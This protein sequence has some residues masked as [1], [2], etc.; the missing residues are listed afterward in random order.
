MIADSR[1]NFWLLF[2]IGN[3]IVLQ[4]L[5]GEDDVVGQFSLIYW[6]LVLPALLIPL[7]FL[8]GIITTLGGRAHFLLYFFI[9]AGAFHLIRGDFRTV[10]QL[11]LLILVLAWCACESTHLSTDDVIKIFFASLILGILVFRFTDWNFWGLLPG[12]T[13][14]EYGGWRVSYF[15]NVANTGTMSLF[16]FLLLTRKIS[17]AKNHKFALLVCLYFLVFSFVRAAFIAAG[18]YL[19][20]RFVFNGSRG[21]GPR[22]LFWASLGTGVGSIL[23][24]AYIVPILEVLQQV[25]ALSRLLLRGQAELDPAAI[26]QQLYRPWLWSQH[27]L[28]FLSSPGQMGL[29]TFN[30]SEHVSF[31]LVPG[32]GGDG[33]ESLPTRLLA[34]YGL[35]SLFFAGYVVHELAR[36]ARA[37]DAWGCA[38]FPGIL[39]MLMNWGS[40]FHPT[41]AFFVLFFL[42]LTR[43]ASAL[44]DETEKKR[45]SIDLSQPVS[46]FDRRGS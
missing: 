28:M 46:S 21:K 24:A 27:F 30:F 11:L 20:L 26:Y 9:L 41:N 1:K 2:F 29:G 40:V 7:M 45:L 22:F 25:P 33:A 3:S 8:P 37:R 19:L 17:I 13:P 12:T 39:F 38:C 16:V 43:G 6:L 42:I 5:L 18:L 4:M 36:L 44:S 14:S 10:M 32:L 31:D 15:P 34:V 23:A 35:P